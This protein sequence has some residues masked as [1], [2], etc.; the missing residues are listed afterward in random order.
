MM[1]K[2]LTGSRLNGKVIPSDDGLIRRS[3]RSTCACRHSVCSALHAEP[4]L[5]AVLALPEATLRPLPT[6]LL[7]RRHGVT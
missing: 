6:G 1:K 4:I 2:Q 5:G 3:L 7:L